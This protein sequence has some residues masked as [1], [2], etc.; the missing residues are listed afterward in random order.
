V[1]LKKEPNPFL[2]VKL[3]FGFR[4]VQKISNSNTTISKS[5]KI[6]FNNNN[7]IK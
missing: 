6:Y 2:N 3:L 1:K 7:N 5:L 4:N